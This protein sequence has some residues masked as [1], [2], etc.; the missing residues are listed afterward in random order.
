MVRF[1]K[2]YPKTEQEIQYHK[3][4]KTVAIDQ[5]LIFQTIEQKNQKHEVKHFVEHDGMPQYAITQIHTCKKTGRD[6]IGWLVDPH[7]KATDTANNKGNQNRDH[8]DISR[9]DIHTY[10]LFY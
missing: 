1:Y 8:I 3:Q 4:F 6:A 7:G 2:F 5:W 9:G 10:Y